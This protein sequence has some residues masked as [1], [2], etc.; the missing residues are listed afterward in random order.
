MANM[1]KKLILMAKVRQKQMSWMDN[2]KQNRTKMNKGG[3]R[4]VMLNNTFL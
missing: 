4:Q 1:D 2:N 3:H